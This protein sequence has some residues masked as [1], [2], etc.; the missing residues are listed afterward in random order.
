MPANPTF[1]ASYAEWST[2]LDALHNYA[3]HL[4]S[5]ISGIE[6]EDKHLIAYDDLERLDRII[7]SFERQF[8]AYMDQTAAALDESASA[9]PS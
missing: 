3:A 6:D 9:P 7:P 4:A 8:Q 5:T 1:K 2:V